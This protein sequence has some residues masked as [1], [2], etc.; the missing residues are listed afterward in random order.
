[1]IRDYGLKA[2]ERN[3]GYMVQEKQNNFHFIKAQLKKS[4]AHATKKA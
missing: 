2:L 4:I 1:V 3:L